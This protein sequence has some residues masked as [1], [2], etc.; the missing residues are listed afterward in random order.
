MEDYKYRHSL[1]QHISKLKG[2]FNIKKT[3][4]SILK[5]IAHVL[6]YKFP[7]GQDFEH[8]PFFYGCSLSKFILVQLH[9]DPIWPSS[10]LVQRV[11]SSVP[12]YH[13]ITWCH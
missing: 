3:A 5:W 6:T 1:L 9:L 7:I 13:G 4:S 11:A 2:S 8:L 12:I 10:I